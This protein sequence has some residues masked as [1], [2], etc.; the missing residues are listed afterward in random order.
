MNITVLLA[1][2]KKMPLSFT[3]PQFAKTARSLGLSQKDV[4]NGHCGKFLHRVAMQAGSNANWVKRVKNPTEDEI[5]AVKGFSWVVQPTKEPVPDTSHL[6]SSA[7]L[8]ENGSIDVSKA[9][10]EKAIAGAI[11]LLKREGYKVMKPT[12]EWI[13]L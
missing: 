5:A 4:K 3:S 7:N 13:E 6:F 11:E 9:M 8:E 12:T 2:Y 10:K 1:A